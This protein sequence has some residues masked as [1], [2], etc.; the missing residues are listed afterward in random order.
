VWILTGLWWFL[1]TFILIILTPTVLHL[2]QMQY[3]IHTA[4]DAGGYLSSN[5]TETKQLKLF[6]SCFEAVCFGFIS[7]CGQFNTCIFDSENIWQQSRVRITADF[8][9][10]ISTSEL[11]RPFRCHA[12]RRLSLFLYLLLV[13]YKLLALDEFFANTVFPIWSRIYARMKDGARSRELG[14]GLYTCRTTLHRTETSNYGCKRRSPSRQADVATA[15]TERYEMDDDDNST[16]CD[17]VRGATARR[18][19]SAV[20]ST[21]FCAAPDNGAQRNY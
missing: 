1:S 2:Q 14:I 17:A 5:E 13:A 4:E 20:I 8:L 16:E 18:N 9:T 6:Q 3:L 10:H 12:I 21:Q 19:F 7:L 15:A 11:K